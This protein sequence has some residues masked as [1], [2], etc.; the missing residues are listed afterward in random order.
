MSI[1]LMKLLSADATVTG[2]VRNILKLTL[3]LE[4][5]LSNL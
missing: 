1:S 3:R 4:N 2:A 5:V